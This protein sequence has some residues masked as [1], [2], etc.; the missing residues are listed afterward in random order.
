MEAH[1]AKRA[2][3]YGS[4]RELLAPFTDAKALDGLEAARR[5]APA[6]PARTPCVVVQ[7]E[8]IRAEL[9]DY[10][11]AS[12]DWFGDCYDRCGALPCI[13]GDEMGLGKTLQTIAFLAW[14]KFEKRAPGASL[15]LCP[16]SVLST[17]LGECALHHVPQP[18]R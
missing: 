6:L 1:V 10:Q 7:P 5:G 18:R 3:F 2:A 16:L 15:V 11:L 12:L 8:E 14:L 17:W 9:R 4:Q 13:L